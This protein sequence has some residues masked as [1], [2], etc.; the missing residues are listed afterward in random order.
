MSGRP[1][2]NWECR[3]DAADALVHGDRATSRPGPRSTAGPTAW[4]RRCS[5]RASATRT[6]SRST[7][8]TAPS[9]SKSTFAIFKAGLVPVN[10]NYRYADDELVYLWDNADAVAR[11]LPRIVRRT[12]RRAPRSRC[13]RCAAGCGSTTASGPCP[14]WAMPYE[15]GRHRARVRSRARWGRSGD[16]LYL[17][18]T[19]GTTGMPKGVMWRQDDLFAPAER[20]QRPVAYAEDDGV[21]GVRASSVE[22][23][24]PVHF[25]ACPLMHGTGGFTSMG[26]PG[27]GGLASSPSTVARFDPVELLD[28]VDREQGQRD[29]HR[30]R[31]LRQAHPR[32]PRR[33]ARPLGP[34]DACSAIISSGVMWSEETKQGL[35]RHKP[36]HDAGRRLRSSEALGMGARSRAD[37]AAG[38]TAKF[39]LGP[40]RP[41][42]RPR[43]QRRRAGIGRD[44]VLASAAATRRLLQG[45]GQVGGDVQDDRR[46]A[47]VDPRRLRHGR[48][49]RHDPACSGRGSVCHQHRRREGLPRRGRGGPQDLPRGARRRGGRH[50]RRAVR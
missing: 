15:D 17:L 33:R 20:R 28:T 42:A 9:T 45:P 19:G 25:P 5:T 36:D 49:R 21:D 23:P 14:D 3:R 22:R 35:L 6:R 46:R 39:T 1:S 41:G 47:V 13:P 16:D 12:R 40:R 18:Y 26:M 34:L 10:T 38:P 43:R 11:D 31:R 48:G 7:S 4:P 8:T 27:V 32:G 24:G 30:R 2:P 44:G 50:P 37:R 29:R